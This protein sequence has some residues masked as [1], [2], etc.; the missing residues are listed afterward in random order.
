[1]NKTF[2]PKVIGQPDLKTRNN[3]LNHSAEILDLVIDLLGI[4]RPLFPK[5]PVTFEELKT[6]LQSDDPVK[7]LR[8]KYIIDR[9]IKTPGL[10]MEKLINYDLLDVPEVLFD[11]ALSSILFLQEMIAHVEP[12]YNPLMYIREDENASVYLDDKYVEKVTANTQEVTQNDYQNQ[13][14]TELESLRN[15]L[16]P[17]VFR[18]RILPSEKP[19]RIGLMEAQ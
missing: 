8:K 2:K 5:T 9:D 18:Y 10:S 4:L 19:Q 12:D 15:S 7:V 16:D 3:R 17:G 14:L 1:M 11:L 13:V 6:L